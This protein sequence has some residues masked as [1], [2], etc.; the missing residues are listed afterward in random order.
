M[1]EKRQDPTKTD[2]EA[3]DLLNRLVPDP[4]NP[5]VNVLTGVFLGR[6]EDDRSARLYTTVRLTQYFQLPKDK[7][8]GVK[9]FPTGQLA[10]WIPGDLRVQV[11][12]S[13]SFSGDFLKGNIQAAFAKR[14]AGGLG[15]AA[16]LS[17]QGP[18]G[19]SAF[20]G[21]FCTTDIPDPTNPICGLTQAG[22]PPGPGC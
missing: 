10:V 12:T 15:A 16:R 20:P 7:I 2:S 19:A 18:D 1:A 11:V 3:T 4:S 8:L 13:N 21:P 9:R 17:Q 14:G 22:C 5:D 6:A